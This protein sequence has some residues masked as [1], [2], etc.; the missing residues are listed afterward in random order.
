MVY[1]MT[2]KT[3]KFSIQKY[4]EVNIQIVKQ[5]LQNN[6]YPLQFIQKYIKIR[7]KTKNYKFKKISLKI[8]YTVGRFQLKKSLT[9]KTIK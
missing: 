3:S 9:R 1:N 5:M 8:R 2:D 6:H 4:V 7:L